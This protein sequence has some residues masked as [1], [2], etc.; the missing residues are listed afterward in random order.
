MVELRLDYCT[1]L[2]NLDLSILKQYRER[3]ILTIRDPKEG[4]ANLVKMETKAALLQTAVAEGFLVDLEVSNIGSIPLNSVGQILSRHYLEEEP[5][6]GELESLVGEYE[7]K[8]RFFKIALKKSETS[9]QKLISL[10]NR[11]RNLVA[12]ETDGDP[13]SRILYSLLGSGLVYCHVGEKTSPGQTSCR[14]VSKIFG[15]LEN[16]A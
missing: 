10:L 3:L 6:Y 1:N 15:L 12:M 9:S 11:H 8:C 16:L 5:S 2:G 7:G 14:S 4:G 13:A